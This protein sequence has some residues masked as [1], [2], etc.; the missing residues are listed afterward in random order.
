M[1]TIKIYFA[2]V[3]FLSIVACNEKTKKEFH[4]EHDDFKKEIEQMKVKLDATEAQLLNVS[5]ELSNLK[6]ELQT[7]TTS[8]NA[9]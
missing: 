3:L 5:A 8:T 7:D 1:K 2:V 6:N 4:A 9:E